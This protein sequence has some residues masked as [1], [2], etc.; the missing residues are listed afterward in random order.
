MQPPSGPRGRGSVRRVLL[1]LVVGGLAMAGC[2]RAER[3]ITEIE[4]EMRALDV[5]YLTADSGRE[6]RAPATRGIFVDEA[7]GEL[8]FPAYQ[9]GDPDCPGRKAEDRPFLF[10]HRDVM[11][12]AGPDGAVV[13]D[14]FPA[15]Q[16]PVAFIRSRGGFPDP[17]CPACRERPGGRPDAVGGARDA[18]WVQ[19]YTLPETAARRS[20]LEEEYQRKSAGRGGS[21]RRPRPSADA[22]A[23]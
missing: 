10:V 5:L 11:L 13:R 3:S 2:Q 20:Q 9:C 14:A 4:A 21:R 16:D 6:V 23:P 17:T 8:C 22:Q 12:R 19:P 7:T 1:P 18:D 15:G